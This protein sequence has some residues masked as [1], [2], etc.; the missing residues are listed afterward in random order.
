M[1]GVNL[2]DLLG[3]AIYYSSMWL[4]GRLERSHIERLK[5]GESYLESASSQGEEWQP[6]EWRLSC[7]LLQKTSVPEQKLNISTVMKTSSLKQKNLQKSSKNY[8]SGSYSEIFVDHSAILGYFQY[9]QSKDI[10]SHTSFT[11]KA[12]KG[13]SKIWSLQYI[14]SYPNRSVPE[15]SAW[16]FCDLFTF[17]ER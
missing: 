15:K 10:W 3:P 7:S 17:H 4:V 12:Q 2:Q 9:L 5:P 13:L 16:T 11:M 14:S 8:E 1:G 6:R